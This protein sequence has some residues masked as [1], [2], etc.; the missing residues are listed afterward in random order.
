MASCS[1]ELPDYLQAPAHVIEDTDII[2]EDTLWIRHHDTP[3]KILA[4]GNSFTNNATTS[5]PWLIHTLN[6][7]SI[8]FAKLTQSGSSLGMHWTNHV[9]DSSEYTLY[10]SERDHWKLSGIKTIDDALNVLDWDIIIFQQLSGLSGIYGAYQPY[11]DYL[12]QLFYA[13]NPDALLGWHYT[14][15]YTPWSQHQDFKNYHYS[16]EKMYAAILEA[17]DRASEGFDFRIPSATLIK[18]MREDYPEVENGFSED[19]CHITDPLAQ[20]ALSSLWYEILIH[21]SSSTSCLNLTS[22]PGFVDPQAFQKALDILKD[23]L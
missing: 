1:K 20:Y 14:W 15:A 23:I 5:M 16:S 21:P 2:Y 22:Y 10:Y 7:D 9:Y 4:I 8:C 3:L 17:A 18:R 6:N 12:V 11:L 13:T 19:G